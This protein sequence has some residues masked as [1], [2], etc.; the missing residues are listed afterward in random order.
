VLP[1]VEMRFS[2]VATT[3]GQGYANIHWVDE[4]GMETE[5]VLFEVTAAQL[6]TLDKYEG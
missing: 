3:G 4:E 5:G 1:G 2:K 6:A